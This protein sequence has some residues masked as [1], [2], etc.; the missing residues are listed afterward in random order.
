MSASAC[1]VRCVIVTLMHWASAV[2]GSKYPEVHGSTS[3]LLPLQLP[4]TELHEEWCSPGESEW[5]LLQVVWMTNATLF[6]HACQM[7]HVLRFA[8]HNLCKLH[9]LCRGVARLP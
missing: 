6:L 4:Y 7:F 3:L 8:R 2:V 1:Q 5:L 9:V